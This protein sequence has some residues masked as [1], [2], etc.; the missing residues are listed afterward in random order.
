M[1]HFQCL[2]TDGFTILLL[3]KQLYSMTLVAS[4]PA[5]SNKAI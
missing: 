5:L 2:L 3:K 4:N 1:N